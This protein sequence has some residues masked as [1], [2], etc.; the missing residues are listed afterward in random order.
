M[1]LIIRCEP[2]KPL[3][4]ALLQDMQKRNR[5]GWGMMWID[6]DLNKVQTKKSHHGDFAALWNQYQEVKHFPELFI[7]LRM[8]THG[9]IDEVNTHPY[10]CGH[11]IWLMHNGVIAIDSN[12]DK[13]KSDTWHFIHNW[14]RPLL[15]QSNNPHSL[16]RSK[17]IKAVIEKLIGTQNRIVM[18]DRGGFLLF[19]E[20]TWHT[21]TNE[22]TGVKGLHVSNTYAWDAYGF[23]KPTT[24]THHN[25]YGN[26]GGYWN[27]ESLDYSKHWNGAYSVPSNRHTSIVLTKSYQ[28]EMTH[29]HNNIY[30]DKAG[31]AWRKQ[32][33][34]W[35]RQYNL[36][37]QVEKLIEAIVKPKSPAEDPASKCDFVQAGVLQLP[38]PKSNEDDE[39][40]NLSTTFE[41]GDE[42][43]EELIA[44]CKGASDSDLESLV[45]VDT[46]NAIK[47][48][49]YL[50]DKHVQPVHSPV[51]TDQH[52][53]SRAST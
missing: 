2:N 25:S 11:G 7:H 34:R 41:L 53:E 35:I 22:A 4:E 38:P 24:H 14:L 44:E 48:L 18:G 15:D 20:H 30:C 1:C 21:I 26:Y 31:R 33:N 23:G 43:Y 12:S 16:I 28:D 50:L 52:N 40:S 19:N 6:P 29:V 46:D 51:H 45:Y 42:D 37:A 5:D 27:D 8:K 47:L 39:V 10:Y 17:K 9:L 13:T 32:R 36:D 49:R 3:S